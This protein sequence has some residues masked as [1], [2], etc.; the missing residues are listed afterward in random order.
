MN[1]KADYIK[2][3]HEDGNGLAFKPALPP[4][5]LQK[6]VIQLAHQHGFLVVAHA[7]SLQR[8]IDM[9]NAGVDGMTHT[10]CDNPPT[11]EL[12]DAYLANNA[13]VFEFLLLVAM[14]LIILIIGIAIR[15]WRR[16]EA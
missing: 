9:L 3:M 10:F 11:K 8:T 7:L 12:I 1:D 6:D 15:H 5:E 14:K 16:L 13:Y 4:L 2:V